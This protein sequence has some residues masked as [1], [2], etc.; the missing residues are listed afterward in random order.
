MLRNSSGTM[1][2]QRGMWGREADRA[3]VDEFLRNVVSTGA[4]IRIRGPRGIGKTSLLA[5]AQRQAR[6]AGMRVLTASGVRAEINVDYGVLGQLLAQLAP[7]LALVSHPY[8]QTL[9]HALDGRPAGDLAAD[10]IGAALIDLLRHASAAQ[11][12]LVSVDDVHW[13]DAASARALAP[14]AEQVRHACLGVICAEHHSRHRSVGLG[15]PLASTHL[16]TQELE[17]LGPALAASLVRALH[18]ELDEPVI[19]AVVAHAAGNPLVLRELANAVSDQTPSR[20]EPSYWPP[21]TRRLRDLIEPELLNLS[22]ATRA[23]L[24]VAALGEQSSGD[25]DS[26]DTQWGERPPDGVREGV[27]VDGGGTTITSDEDLELLREAERIGFI[28]LDDSA[29][30]I[31][32]NHPL[33]PGALLQLATSSERR[34]AHRAVADRLSSGVARA[35]HLA[36]ATIRPDDTVAAM[37]QQTARRELEAGRSSRAVRCLLRAADLTTRAAERA[38][39]VTEVASIRAR[40]MGDLSEATA[41]LGRAKTIDPDTVSLRGLSTDAWM[42]LHQTGD[43]ES[44]HL[45][46]SQALES[47][48]LHDYDL[49]DENASTEIVEVF[50]VLIEVCFYADRKDLWAGFGQ[51]VTSGGVTAPRAGFL[52][53]L[54]TRAVPS[55]VRAGV[56]VDQI[57][58]D[59]A[60]ERDPR[61]VIRSAV[62]CSQAGETTRVRPHLM[63]LVA[64]RRSEHLVPAIWAFDLLAGDSFATGHWAE[65]ERLAAEGAGACQQAGLWLLA[66]AFTYRRALLA[67]CRGDARAA[68]ALCAR[69]ERW[70]AP[71]SVRIVQIQAAHARTMLSLSTRDYESAYRYAAIIASSSTS[72]ARTVW[73]AAQQLDA[74]DAAVLAG[75][76]LE[77]REWLDAL[78][79]S[80]VATLSERGAMLVA[81]AEAISSEELDRDLFEAALSLP[82]AARFPFELARLEL[83]YGQRLRRVRSVAE[84]RTH[85]TRAQETFEGMGADAWATQAGDE[86]AATSPARL[87]RPQRVNA[88]LTARERRVAELAASGMTNRQIGERLLIS[89]RTTGAHLRH[90]FEK[91][92]INN[93]AMLADALAQA[94]ASGE[95]ARDSGGSSAPRTTPPGSTGDDAG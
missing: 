21:L 15:R 11:P 13:T 42:R 79:H 50:D 53:D 68:E 57:L 25:D 51:A 29:R 65:A 82:G 20:D 67:A 94:D 41:L 91:L 17:P 89:A 36:A 7:D 48:L 33:V 80:E 69:M 44:A 10:H 1:P 77:G 46:L 35:E 16:P 62:A 71:T 66:E 9:R 12:V 2:E 90:I 52:A 5:Y 56:N 92:A 73:R 24:L 6:E 32:F 85:L 95:P 83:R 88:A 28:R 31:T 40:L 70:S 30:T 72:A 8:R 59:I 55:D 78:R 22:P 39:C 38:A 75:R 87:V 76:V 43:L 18:P 63:R 74:I 26:R 58:H 14:L 27:G 34:A 45:L 64:V 3:A 47:I 61:Q 84:A 86:W 37:L 49:V 23:L 19:S 4:A 81:T 60:G 54:M 93:R